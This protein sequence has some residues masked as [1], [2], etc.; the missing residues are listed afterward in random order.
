VERCVGT[1][2]NVPLVLA[3]FFESRKNP[4]VASPVKSEAHLNVGAAGSQA[5]FGAKGNWGE[6]R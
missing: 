1:S 3:L 5:E 2:P 6:L 4:K